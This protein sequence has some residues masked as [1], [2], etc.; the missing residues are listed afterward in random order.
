MSTMDQLKVTDRLSQT[1]SFPLFGVDPRRRRSSR[2]RA[3]LWRFPDKR[4]R[5]L[6]FPQRVTS[7]GIGGPSLGGMWGTFP[8]PYFVGSDLP[9]MFIGLFA[10][11]P[12]RQGSS[13]GHHLWNSTV[14][15]SQ[16][17]FLHR[18]SAT[19]SGGPSGGISL[20][21]PPAARGKCW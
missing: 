10:Q 18:C 16:S 12:A 20:V 14:L 4:H 6:R 11:L 9:S 8:R 3:H 1:R 7:Q 15:G 19:G 17:V 13:R 5:S 21:V 2:P